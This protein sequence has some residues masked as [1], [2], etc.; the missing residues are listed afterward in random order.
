MS[1]N[2]TLRLA[3]K[4]SALARRAA[5]KRFFHEQFWETRWV[6]SWIAFQDSSLLC[7]IGSPSDIKARKRYPT[8]GRRMR[9]V[10]PDKRL[11]QALQ[12]G[13][14]R[15]L[16]DGSELASG[17]WQKGL[18][19]TDPGIAF[20]RKDVLRCW[21]SVGHITNNPVRPP[22]SAVE[23]FVRWF[24]ET[25]RKEGR[26]VSESSLMKAANEKALG[27]SR[28]Q[29]RSAREKIDPPKMGRPGKVAGK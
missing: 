24:I 20:R 21:R 17:A 22:Q 29:L 8:L 15:A 4:Q 1:E 9:V 23:K 27:A 26:T 28:I 3:Q 2:D 13:T 18:N 19:W 11:L 16:R 12:G 6:V 5:S 7:E 14:I 25:E 10:D